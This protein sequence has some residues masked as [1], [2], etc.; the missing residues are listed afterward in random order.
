MD[1]TSDAIILLD[2]AGLVSWANERAAELVGLDRDAWIGQSP[3]PLVHPDDLALAAEALTDTLASSGIQV[4]IEIRVACA[5]GSWALVELVGN[6]RVGDRLI[7]GI[8]LTGRRLGW[9]RHWRE[10]LEMI[11]SLI[12]I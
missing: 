12:H 8:V 7:E 2:P 5:D 10:L 4:P 9:R 11:L 3:L 1:A 6:S